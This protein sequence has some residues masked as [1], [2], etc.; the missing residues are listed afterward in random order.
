MSKYDVVFETEDYLL[1]LKYKRTVLESNTTVQALDKA[2]KGY[3]LINKTFDVV[4]EEFSLLP[5]AL[6]TIVANQQLLDK[7]RK[8]HKDDTIG[9]A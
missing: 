3:V 5:R 2:V 1:A 8:E 9:K 7:F 4:E 6:Y